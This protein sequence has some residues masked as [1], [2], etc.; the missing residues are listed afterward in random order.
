MGTTVITVSGLSRNCIQPVIRA[1]AEKCREKVAQ[2]AEYEQMDD[3][4]ERQIEKR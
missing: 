1:H 4:N 3:G 2:F